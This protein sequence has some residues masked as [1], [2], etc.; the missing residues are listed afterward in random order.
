MYL[1]YLQGE[2]MESL[3]KVKELNIK[4]LLINGWYIFKNNLKEALV[5]IGLFY[6][7]KDIID[8]FYSFSLDNEGLS[9]IYTLFILAFQLVGQLAIILIYAKYLQKDYVSI[10][11]VLKT[12]FS[13]WP[14]ALLTNAILFIFIGILFI[15]LIVPAI[16]GTVYL[17]FVNQAIIL[18]ETYLHEALEYSYS[19][20]KGRWWKVFTIGI[21][22]IIIGYGIS[23]TLSFLP[24]SKLLTFIIQTI[25]NLFYMYGLAI[26]TL[27]FLNL[28][29][30]H[31]QF[32]KLKQ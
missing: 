25:A 10:G 23:Y 26:Q 9:L 29:I 24:P 32:Q 4:N 3:V 7:P 30:I 14:K 1:R 20:V 13:T 11:Q 21:I 27:Y 31:S 22:I 19:L 28:D 6:I 16:I 8:I 12:S 18:K 5:V 2:G 15:F 17:T